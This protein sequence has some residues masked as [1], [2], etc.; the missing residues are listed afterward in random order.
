[1][2]R[3]TIT[4]SGNTGFVREITARVNSNVLPQQVIT[5]WVNWVLTRF[6]PKLY[7]D[8]GAVSGEQSRWAPLSPWTLERRSSMQML[9]ES[10]TMMRSYNIADTR[11]SRYSHRFV[12][13]NRARR[14][15]VDYPSIIQTGTRAYDIYPTTPGRLLSWTTNTGDR[16]FFKKTSRGATPPRVHISFYRVQIDRLA[17]MIMNFLTTG[18]P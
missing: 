10:G 16:Y 17:T 6:I 7:R 15:G 12:M 4:T 11:V 5:S 9:S 8:Q 18:K 14:G 13:S 2:I 3:A 1:M